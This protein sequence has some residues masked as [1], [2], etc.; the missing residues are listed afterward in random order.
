[1][2]KQ[3]S[4]KKSLLVICKIL[5]LF[6]NTLSAVDKYSVLNRDNL[7][8]PIQMQLSQ[9]HKTFFGFFSAF[10][11]SCLNFQHFQKKDDPHTWFIFEVTDS[12]KRLKSC[13]SEDHSKSR[14]LNGPKY[15]WNFNGSSFTIFIDHCQCNSVAKILC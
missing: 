13:V 4:C 10:L 14:M 6:V 11:K 2:W 5:R 1:M 3:L 7:I 12:E 9:K 8:Q 15:C